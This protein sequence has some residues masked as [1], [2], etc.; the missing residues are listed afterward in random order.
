VT[1]LTEDPAG[2]SAGS[3][4]PDGKFVVFESDREEGWRIF[5][6]EVDSGEVERIPTSGDASA[7]VWSQ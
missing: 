4:S 2:D 5:F 3:W 7:P 1:N 6:L